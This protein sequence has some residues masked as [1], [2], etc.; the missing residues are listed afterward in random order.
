MWSM[1]DIILIKQWDSMS[2]PVSSSLDHYTSDELLVPIPRVTV[3]YA[4]GVVHGDVVVCGVIHP[5][6]T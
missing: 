5:C 6:Q 3:E 2:I 1:T 4:R